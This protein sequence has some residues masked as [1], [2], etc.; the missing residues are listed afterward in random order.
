MN[1]PGPVTVSVSEWAEAVP[2]VPGHYWWRGGRRLPATIVR[3]QAIRR[4]AHHSELRAYVPG[5][6]SSKSL[7]LLGGEWC[8]TI[9]EPGSAVAPEDV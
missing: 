7:G 1:R 2:S 4:G 3:V 5:Q 6:L 9:P 8:G